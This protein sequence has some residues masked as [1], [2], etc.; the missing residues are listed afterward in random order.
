MTAPERD[1]DFEAYLQRRSALQR[2]FSEPDGL[3][4]PP[5]LDRIVLARARQAITTR[6]E[7]PVYKPAKWAFPLALAATVVVSFTIVLSMTSADRKEVALSEPELAMDSGSG[8]RVVERDVRR[9]RESD[10]RSDDLVAQAETAAAA[11]SAYAPPPPSAAAQKS[12]PYLPAEEPAPVRLAAQALQAASSAAGIEHAGAAEPEDAELAQAEEPEISEAPA[13]TSES[14]Q[15]ADESP[16][17]AARAAPRS[18]PFATENRM[19]EEV[20]VS[21]AHAR[22]PTRA[23]RRANPDLWLAYIE[24][25]RDRGRH[26]AADRELRAFRKRYPDYPVPPEAERAD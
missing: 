5:E 9:L 4:P 22:A 24:D 2:E 8:G 17:V 15:S 25:L 18:P 7:P 3:E 19:L 1:E 14:A 23:E 20:T 11:P 6:F 16:R 10:L 26:S 12:T 21:G 13:D